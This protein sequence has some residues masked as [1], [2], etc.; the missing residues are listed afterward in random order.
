M[1]KSV[2]KSSP[3]RAAIRGIEDNVG[4]DYLIGLKGAHMPVA[5]RKTDQGLSGKEL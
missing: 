3:M 1:R 5:R 4:I 2:A